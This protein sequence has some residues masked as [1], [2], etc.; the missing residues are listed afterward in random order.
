MPKVVAPLFS[1]LFGIGGHYFREAATLGNF[2]RIKL[3]VTFGR[4]LRSVGRYFRG[5]ATFGFY[6]ILTSK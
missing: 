6:G 4:P 5:A 1:D 2:R 3:V